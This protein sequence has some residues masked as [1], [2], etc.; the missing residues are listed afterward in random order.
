[1]RLDLAWI[2]G[3]R[4]DAAYAV[5]ALAKS[6]GFTAAAVLTLAIGIGATTAVCSIVNTVLFEPL[7]LTDADRLVQ[8]V[9]NG[10]PRDLPVVTYREYLE[11]QPRPTTLSGLTAAGF[12]SQIIL[13]V[14]SGLVRVTGGFVAPNYFEV[15]GVRP[16]LGRPL[17]S[18]DAASP[19]VMVLA[20][21]S[22]QRHF[23]SDPG[24]IGRVAAFRSGPLA[25]RSLTVVGVLPES[26][27]TIGSPTAFYT[28]IDGLPDPRPIAVGGMIGRV[29][30]GVSLAAASQEANAIGTAVRP[31]RPASA[32]PLSTARFEVRS[33]K[34]SLFEPRPGLQ[35]TVDMATVLRVFLGATAAVLL[36]VC[37]NVANLL[38][39]RGTARRRELATRLALGASRWQLL[40]QILA[41]CAVLAAAGGIIGAAV[42]AAGVSLVRRLATVEAQGVFRIVFGGNLLPRGEEIGVDVRLLGIALAVSVVATFAF[43]LLPAL[44]LSRT[45]QLEALG[46][47]GAATTQRDTRVRMVLVVGELALA[48][49]LLVGAG[50]LATSFINLTTVKKGYDPR[51]VLAFQLVLP[52]EYPTARKAE[53][54]EAVLRAVRALPGVSVAGFAYAGILIGVQDTVGSF[55]P[56]GGRLDAVAKEAERPRLKTLGSG[57]LEAAGATLLEGRL[58]AGGDSG[59]A[60]PVAVINQTTQRRYFGDTSPVGASMDWHGGAGGGGPHVPVQIVG[61]VA[62]IRQGSLARE[63]Y[64]EIFMD[65]RQVIALQQRWGASQARV[66]SL[67]FGFMSFAMR[68]RA[69]PGAVVAQVRDAITRADPNAALDAIVPM[70][71]LVANSVARH[72]FY[73]VMLTLL[74]AVA[75][76]LAAIGIYGVLAYSVVERTREIGLR[77]ALGARR[78]T[79]LALVLR[80]GL[81]C[82]A[83]GILLGLAG[84]AA[85]TRYLR[86]ILY[87][88]T[89]LDGMTFV[90]V[91]LTFAGVAAIAS[92]VPANRA[93]RVDPMVALRNE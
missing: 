17:I 68:T 30:A 38:L 34:D 63:P 71:S 50:L 51:N 18:G 60:A 56:P 66:D 62:D 33:L 11:W 70:D 79:V 35:G 8:V 4:R 55:V 61:V 73:A 21:Y 10:R 20:Y 42:G 87:G 31:P 45:N 47:R 88:I 75:G 44:H 58:I 74:A 5:R 9:E 41:E 6:R 82:A 24:V 86:A 65:Y 23:A 26:M 43:G 81:T 46:S 54:I 25:G 48:T 40:R 1:M 77:M 49:I 37:A 72:R 83:I 90:M 36:I 69:D 80:R 14:P 22:W 19:D 12:H 78:Q 7:P 53:T 57:Y 64:P 84:A 28:P 13:P 2:D 16:L 93:T 67:A 59:Q 15:L 76:L 85:G 32:P 29:R 91:A 27:E 39:A 52:G 89:P 92:Y 3:A